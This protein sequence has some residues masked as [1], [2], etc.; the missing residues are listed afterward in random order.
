MEHINLRKPKPF[1]DWE[2]DF[3]RLVYCDHSLIDICEILQRTG[4]S[5][6][7]QAKTLGLKFES[8]NINI[9][10]TFGM[11]TVQSRIADTKKRSKIWVCICKCGKETKAT[12][13]TLLSKHSESCGCNRIKKIYTGS[14]FI[15]GKMYNKICSDAKLRGLEMKVSIKELDCLIE[16][17]NFTCALTGQKLIIDKT[18]RSSKTTASLDRIDNSQGYIM[19]NIQFIHKDI[20][21]LKWSFN[22]EY[23]IKMCTMV[24]NYHESS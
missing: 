17:Q 4:R 6:K 15:T 24:A 2:C 1:Q 11:L 14:K 8:K 18:S 13:N 21:R 20:N 9:G 23:F 3:L 22:Q 19:G 16:K 5:I 7:K 12:T 10:D